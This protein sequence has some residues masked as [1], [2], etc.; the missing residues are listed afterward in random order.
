MA[1]TNEERG[2]IIRILN[3]NMRFRQMSAQLE[4]I[5]EK[6]KGRNKNS[7]DHAPWVNI[8]ACMKSQASL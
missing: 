1:T 2:I 5:Q 4:E 3:L 8:T 7:R 6:F